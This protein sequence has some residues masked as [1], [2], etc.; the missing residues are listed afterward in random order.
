MLTIL[1]C[2]SAAHAEEVASRDLADLSLEE[3]MGIEVYSAAKKKQRLSDSAAAAYVL[4]HE[5]IRRSG[6]TSIPEALRLVPGVEVARI[7]S[8][9]WAITIRGFNERFANKLLVLIDGR[10][11]YTPLFAGVYWDI[12]DVVLEDIDR[13]EVIRGPGGTLWGANAVNGVI[14]IITKSAKET[15]GALLSAGAGTE[16]EGFGTIR[17]GAQIAPNA[18]GRVYG[19]YFARDDFKGTTTGRDDASDEWHMSHGGFRM[20][21]EPQESDA[22]TLQGDVYEAEVGSFSATAEPPPVFL[23]AGTEHP[24]AYGGNLLARWTHRFAGGSEAQLQGYY[25]R[26]DRDSRPQTVNEN[27]NTADLEFQHRLKIWD[28]HDIVWGLGYRVTWD[29]IPGS[30][31][32]SFDPEKQ[33]DNLVSAFLQDEISFLDDSVRLTLGTKLEHNDYSG[34]EVQPNVRGLWKP[35]E[36]DTLWGAISRA[37]RTPSRSEDAIRIVSAV[38][39]AGT[40]G[41]PCE[42]SPFPCFINFNGDSDFEAEE[43]LAFELGYRR[44]VRENLGLDLTSFYNIYDNLRT[45]V[46]GAPGFEDNPPTHLVIPINVGN[47]LEGET[48]GFELAADWRPIES[49]TLRSGYTFFEMDLSFKDGAET[50]PVSGFADGSSPQNQL[51]VHSMLDLP[52]DFEFDTK[53]RWVDDLKSLDIE[54]YASLDLRLGWHATENIELSLVGQNLLEKTNQEFESSQFVS[55]EPTKVERG[56]YGKVTLEF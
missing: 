16:E 11:V 53:F 14:N 45:V 31:S 19:K 21:W 3:L 52:Y 30:F 32:L 10:S 42:T 56:V 5:D 40:P 48:W 41:T 47:G 37:V 6:V 4:T 55:D 54:D 9:K 7:D 1:G 33:T 17:Y 50:D 23:S 46:P 20:D 26:T 51:F 34:F 25:D 38:V 44:E 35:D 2:A 22:F 15:Q 18:Y 39:P 13:I 28:R 8:N 12:Q 27:R 24:N 43:L 29:E 36:R 49:W